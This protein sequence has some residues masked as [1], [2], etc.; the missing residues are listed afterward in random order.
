MNNKKIFIA[1][2]IIAIIVVVGGLYFSGAIGND[3][4]DEEANI[5]VLAGAGFSKVC[6]DLISKF[7]EKYPNVK[8]NVKYGGS[9][10]LFSTLETQKEGDVFLPADYKY[11]GKAMENDY[12]DDDSVENITENVPIIVV[13]AGN[14]K[15]IT[16]LDDLQNSDVKVG[17]GEPDG[18]AIGKASERIIEKNN[19]TINPTVTTTTVNQLLTYI[20]SGDIDA[21]IIWKDMTV[22]QEAKNIE[23]VEIPENENSISTIPVGVTQFTDSPDAAHDFED[24]ITSDEG[25]KIWEKWGFEIKS[26]FRWDLNSNGYLLELLQL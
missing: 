14:P 20:V 6:P 5:E 3:G 2:I 21:T 18:P 25:K 19:L 7:N 1:I 17:L 24:F 9:G 26:W 10:E 23:S 16:S 11:M 4:S 13:Q 22:W 12:M 15:N 8:V